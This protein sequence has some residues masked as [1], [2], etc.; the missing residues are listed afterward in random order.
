[1]L[2]K[3]DHPTQRTLTSSS[4]TE[5]TRGHDEGGLQ[6]LLF[7]SFMTKLKMVHSTEMPEFSGPDICSGSTESHEL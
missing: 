5:E 2:K 1:M 7:E 4:D 6:K 3:K